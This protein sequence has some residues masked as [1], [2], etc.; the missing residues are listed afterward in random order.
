MFLVALLALPC[1]FLSVVERGKAGDDGGGYCQI[2]H[3]REQEQEWEQK[4]ELELDQEYE[5]KVPIYLYII[6]K[7][8]I[9]I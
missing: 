4:Q 3:L 2:L 6:G 1:V 7:I 8:K 5:E 9:S